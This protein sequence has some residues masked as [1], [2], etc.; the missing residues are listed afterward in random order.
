M[1]LYKPQNLRNFTTYLSGPMEYQREECHLWRNDIKAKLILL[2]MEPRHIID[3]VARTCE[4]DWRT[5]EDYKQ[6]GEWDA[7]E[8]EGKMIYQED[9]RYVDK[10]D[11]LITHLFEGVKTCGTWDETFMARGQRKPVFVIQPGG[12][13]KASMWLIA[14][15]GWR[16]IFS[17]VDEVIENLRQIRDG[18]ISIPE[19]WR[20]VYHD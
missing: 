7:V 2:G 3:P 16:Q 14:R 11:F 1:S 12:I 8:S 10:S 20:D 4:A 18:E 17:S 15:V 5:L 6:K 9:L 19:G 13:E